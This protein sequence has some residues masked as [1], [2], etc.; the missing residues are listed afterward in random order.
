MADTV[1]DYGALDIDCGQWRVGERW[2]EHVA[3]ERARSGD[4]LA[5]VADRLGEAIGI[6]IG[7]WRATDLLALDTLL[8][9][10]S[11]RLAT[12]AARPATPAVELPQNIRVRIARQADNPGHW[13]ITVTRGRARLERPSCTLVKPFL[14]AEYRTRLL[15]VGHAG[16]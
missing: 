13:S 9:E 12:V 8:G 6:R 16:I 1:M 14:P 10:R 4:S 11:G 5:T 2:L 3:A 7:H 15:R